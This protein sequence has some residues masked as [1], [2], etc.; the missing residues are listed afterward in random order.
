ML[1]LKTQKTLDFKH[2]TKKSPKVHL[3]RQ[4]TY[5]YKNI[6]NLDD[7]IS[8]MDVNI[9][10]IPTIKTKN[11]FSQNPLKNKPNN[12]NNNIITLKNKNSFNIS[13]YKHC[14]SITTNTSC[15]E[16]TMKKVTFST[17]EII[18]VEKYKKY[19]ATSNYSK[20]QIKKN[21]EEFKENDNEQNCVIF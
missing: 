1:K 3:A 20:N 8:E 13:T 6:I 21:M 9:N 16:K 12:N 4:K 19:N 10:Q 11:L 5:D 7:D 14:N 15:G 18:R 17:V 2:K